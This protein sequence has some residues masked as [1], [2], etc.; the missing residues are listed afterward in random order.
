M[1]ATHSSSGWKH[2]DTMHYPFKCPTWSG[3][4]SGAALLHRGC[5]TVKYHRTEKTIT[6]LVPFTLI[7]EAAIH[8]D[9]NQVAPY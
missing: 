4:F 7:Q 6:A 2:A 1:R 8:I 5:V 3:T 9:Y